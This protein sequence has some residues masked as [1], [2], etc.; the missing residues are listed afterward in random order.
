PTTSGTTPR[1]GTIPPADPYAALRGNMTPTRPGRIIQ[2]PDGTYTQEFPQDP[3]LQAK[4]APTATAT[5]AH[6][7][8]ISPSPR[9]S[10]SPPPT[11]D[12]AARIA[13]HQREAFLAQLRDQASWMEQEFRRNNPHLPWEEV[14]TK[15]EIK[16]D[17]A[18]LER[19][20]IT[21]TVVPA[22]QRTLNTG[23]TRSLLG[24]SGDDGGSG[25]DWAGGPASPAEA[26]EFRSSEETGPTLDISAWQAFELGGSLTVARLKPIYQGWDPM[27]A[28]LGSSGRSLSSAGTSLSSAGTSLSAAGTSLSSAGTSFSSAGISPSSVMITPSSAPSGHHVEWGGYFSPTDPFGVRSTRLT[29]PYR[30]GQRYPGYGRDNEPALCGR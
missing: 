6:R 11:V 20:K 10:P 17:P 16:Y 7:P 14:T 5:P 9:P 13:Q 24:G 26:I 2:L 27:T 30:G 18:H 19:S 29:N 23:N 3:A 1:K 8:Q 15:I 22:N 4:A 25:A 28:P 21:I 12:M